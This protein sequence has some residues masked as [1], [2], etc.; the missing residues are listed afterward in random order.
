MLSLGNI[1]PAEDIMANLQYI[2]ADKSDAPSHPVGYLTTENRDVWSSVREKLASAGLFCYPVCLCL[3]VLAC[4]L[5]VS[6]QTCRDCWSILV[7]DFD[8][9][10][11]STA[12][13]TKS[14]GSAAAEMAAQF[15]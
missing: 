3:P 5:T 2:L 6:S 15:V 12:V 8:N 14:Q 10:L 1:R 9:C 11:L 13:K 7:V 4:F